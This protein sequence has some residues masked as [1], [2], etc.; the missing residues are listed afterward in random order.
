MRLHRS[1]LVLTLGALAPLAF[2]GTG[3]AHPGEWHECRGG[4]IEKWRSL[5]VEC[6][7]A[8]DPQLRNVNLIDRVPREF[9]EASI[10]AYQQF[11]ADVT[12]R[13]EARGVRF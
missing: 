5:R 11:E 12:T 4:R 10:A 3:L 13:W 9:L 1:A 6:K 2:P 7:T 8:R